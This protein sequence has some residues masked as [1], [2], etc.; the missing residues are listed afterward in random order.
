MRVAPSERQSTV[1][2]TPEGLLISIPSRRNI[3][4]VLFLC[5]WLVGW[6]FGE[7]AACR[8][9]FDPQ[10]NTADLFLAVW[11]TGWTLGGGAALYI[12]SWMLAGREV[13]ALRPDALVNRRILWGF[14]R[15]REYDLPQ[16]KNLR[17][18]PLVWNPSDWN[19]ALQFWGIGGG[20]IAFDYGAKTIR[21]ASGIDEAEARLIVNELKSRYPFPDA[22]S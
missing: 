7:I 16:V 6:G 8:E 11:L 4:L 21:I 5:L 20:P 14:D 2:Q 1:S 9:L 22:A 19:G 10:K 15:A 12:L 3:F 18:A 13:V 17:V